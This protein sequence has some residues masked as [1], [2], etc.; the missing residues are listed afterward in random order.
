MR[1]IIFV[2]ML[3][4]AAFMA[5]WFKI[6]RDG[7]NTLI[8]IDRAA[9][10]NDTQQAIEKS[11]AVFE[12]REQSSSEPSY[13]D[14]QDAWAPQTASPWAPTGRPP[15]STYVDR[16]YPG[17]APT[18][19]TWQYGPPQAYRPAEPVDPRYASPPYSPSYTYP[20]YGGQAAPDRST[21]AFP[22]QYPNSAG[23]YTQLPSYPAR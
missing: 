18:S 21:P 5:G 12:R 10:R 17:Q 7:E 19:E 6:Q 15:E 22:V 8:E 2:G 13:A 4:S 14:T 20:D 23:P 3:L 11:R 16:S 1:N 9:I